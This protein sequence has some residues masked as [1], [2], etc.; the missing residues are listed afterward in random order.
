LIGVVL[1][2]AC[3]RTKSLYLAI[4]LHAGWIFLTKTNILFFDY[5][6]TMPKWLF[7]DST[8]VTGVLGWIL[9][10]VTLILIRFVTE[11]QFYGKN[12]A[13]TS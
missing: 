2:Y 6:R 13:R 5:L 7:G 12:S 11:A 9:L 3:L 1:S 10:I 4:G 8:V